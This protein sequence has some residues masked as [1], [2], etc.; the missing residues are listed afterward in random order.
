MQTDET[1]M[2]DLLDEDD[3][4]G[5]GSLDRTSVPVSSLPEA[6]V[7]LDRYSWHRLTPLHV[8]PEFRLMILGELQKRGTP[9]EVATWNS[10]ACGG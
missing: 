6:L 10:Q 3:Q 8:H 9:E 4:N 7:L 5:L 1:T 2:F